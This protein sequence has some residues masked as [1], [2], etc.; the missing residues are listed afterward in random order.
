M[1]VSF[2]KPKEKNFS[3][4]SDAPKKTTSSGGYSRVPGSVSYVES[5]TQSSQDTQTITRSSSRSS[6]GSSK[7]TTS[8]STK[9]TSPTSTQSP[10]E[11]SPEPST[12]PTQTQSAQQRTAQF[13]Q[14]SSSF[15]PNAGYVVTTKEGVQYS[16]TGR[17]ATIAQIR[18]R[19]TTPTPVASSQ[20]GGTLTRKQADAIKRNVEREKQYRS[21]TI[22]LDPSTGY[23]ENI[24]FTREG[25]RAALQRIPDTFVGIGRQVRNVPTRVT[26]LF[27]ANKEP[28]PV[29]TSRAD[30]ITK[31]FTDPITVV[32]APLS[33]AAQTTRTVGGFVIG[34][35]ATVIVKEGGEQVQ[36]SQ[37]Q[38]REFQKSNPELASQSSEAGRE[39][40]R[41]QQREEFG[42]V[43]GKF[44]P[45]I[46]LEQT[47]GDPQ[48]FIKGGEQFL[49]DRGVSGKQL[50]QGRN[51]LA[52]EARLNPATEVTGLLVSEVAGNIGGEG[53]LTG[54]IRRSISTSEKN[55]ARSFFG[56]LSEGATAVG[57]Q[58]IAENREIDPLQVAVG[59]GIGGLTAGT[60]E[61]GR[62][63][64]TVPRTVRG[65]VNV[66]ANIVEPQEFVVDVAQS[67]IERLGRGR[68]RAIGTSLGSSSNTFNTQ[69][70]SFTFDISKDA[71][72]VA[73]DPAKTDSFNF[74]V[75][76]ADT[77]T[78]SITRD[79]TK[80]DSFTFTSSNT[81]TLTNT[82]VNSKT[83]TN[84][85]SLATTQ[86][87]VIAF[88]P[89]VALFP[90]GGGGF[91]SGGRRRTSRGFQPK[92]Y[93]PSAFSVL[94]NLKSS[95]TS[96]G[97]GLG[98][99][100]IKSTSSKKSKKKGVLRY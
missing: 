27:R 14:V 49:V 35:G 24:F 3:S 54:S 47:S 12:Q 42:F 31:F 48:T 77:K 30:P 53:I 94:T 18:N 75:A 81:N 89:D 11:P 65:V 13:N 69:P 2:Y 21:T 51:F 57:T 23:S 8:P 85:K 15:D 79:T 10:P 16:T 1:A 4:E 70:Q 96:S 72:F 59:A 91:G 84:S 6:G 20:L 19:L 25:Q 46:G 50:E 67:G 55:V 97:G 17:G 93:T 73:P 43:R 61:F 82:F 74:N 95:K 98:I 99:R 45:F 60:I 33:G 37:F 87:R 86:A 68:S 92:T 52:A 28:L 63:S 58:S 22:A 39:A 66:G 41:K 26:N 64:K 36:Q 32:T 38:V 9:S 62:T 34:L 80:T 100:P 88:T 40:V 56:G 71:K 44:L 83:F 7:R 78:D 29:D 5:A 90:L 76:R